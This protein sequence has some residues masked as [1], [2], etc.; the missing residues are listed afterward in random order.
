M[1]ELENH[2]GNQNL[3]NNSVPQLEQ[4][5]PAK[6]NIREI[7]ENVVRLGL[8]ELS[9][10]IGTVIASIALVLLVVWVMG[11]FYLG[12]KINEN[13]P[14][15]AAQIEETPTP[16]VEMP[17]FEMP[18][19]DIETVAL[20]RY[21]EL[22][23]TLPDKPRYEI[24][25]YTVQTGD[26]LFDIA[27]RFG[28]EPSTLLWGNLYILGDNPHNLKPGQE[29]NILPQDGVLHKWSAGEGLNGVSSYY[30]VAPETIIDW[31]GNNLSLETIGDF[32]NPNIAP[33]TELFVPGGQ[34]EFVTWSAP[35]ITRSDPA[36]AKL[37][38]PGYCGTI[39]EGANGIGT[40]VWP[41]TARYI[42]GY[43][44][45][46]ATAHFGIDIGGNSGNAIYATDNGVV[47]YSGWNNYGYGNV[48]VIDHGNGW[49]TL[50]AHL[51]SDLLP[52]CGASVYQG[53]MIAY[54]GSTGNSSGPHLHFE[55]R[56]DTYGKVDPKL[57]VQ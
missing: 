19:A 34:R 27:D 3:E 21:T 13:A 30:G 45:S 54:M 20:D 42:S 39:T 12:G 38:G 44:W 7:W 6:K 37:Y 49:Q 31:P 55:M 18:N 14:V 1:D 24:V 47:V 15:A 32:A 50:Y 46:P 56:N 2:Q 8:G 35:R 53:D 23:T 22:H 17:P 41:T 51:L 25:K 29:L 28:L 11:R 5:L 36:V 9:L 43:D 40:F 57:F 33:E 52:L 16:M 26:T 48:V 4:L 10:R